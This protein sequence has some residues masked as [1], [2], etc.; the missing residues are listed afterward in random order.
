MMSLGGGGDQ[1]RRGLR[2]RSCL[3]GLALSALLLPSTG[4]ALVEATT[5][6]PEATVG[7]ASSPG[8]AIS[9]TPTSVSF[10][11]QVVGTTGSKSVT[12][13]NTGGQPFFA[14]GAT[15]SSPKPVVVT[16]GGT[17]FD[18]SSSSCTTPLQ[19][20]KSC[21]IRVTFT[22][23]AF[24]SYAGTLYVYDLPGG[25]QQI[26]LR[27]N[28][29]APSPTPIASSSPTSSPSSASLA[30]GPGPSLL[31]DNRWFSQTAFRIDNDTVWSYFTARGGVR[32]F[33]YP[34]SRTF[35]FL[36]QPTQFFQLQI[37]QVGPGNQPR[38]M[39]LLDPDLMP[40]TTINGSTFPGVDPSV[41]G[42]APTPNQPDYSTAIIDFIRTNTPEMF[43]G[44]NT[45][46]FT[47]FSNAVTL[48]DAFPT[49][50]GD[51]NLLPALNLELWGSVTS[52]STHDP[53][54]PSFVYLRFQ[55]SIMMFDG[56]TGVTQGVL[57]ADYFK[58]IITGQNL[59]PDL[60]AQAKGSRFYKQY[61]PNNPQWLDRPA[62]LPGTDFSN[63]FTPG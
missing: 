60:E 47:A 26:P 40:Y 63:A 2:W 36:G 4:L 16:S 37:V 59:P 18:A 3:A 27:G 1:D 50:G 48:A 33:G 62:D 57:L 11:N 51:P 32:T 13:T 10:G 6:T 31:H 61:N 25:T 46:F 30:G 17:G 43:D 28:G 20:G 41:A 19:P 34:A 55:R 42:A 29:I 9:I 12:L 58:S 49:G 53:A 39:N 8:P 22:P 45:R 5:A 7:P 52:K 23:N 44:M 56:T 54:N 21:K 24:A 15:S 14:Q 38:T 35:T